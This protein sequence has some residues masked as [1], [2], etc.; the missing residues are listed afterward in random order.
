LKAAY[1][2]AGVEA[3]CVAFIDDTWPNAMRGLT[4]RSRA[5]VR[6]RCPELAA[7]GLGAL[8]AL[9]G[10]IADGKQTA[11]ADLLVNAKAAFRIA[12]DDPHGR[13]ARGTPRSHR[14]GDGARH[15]D[16]GA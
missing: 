10:V 7:I 11:N 4:S 2:D 13:R 12:Q 9:P 3:E 6:S 8:I 15:G 14:P 1:R 5:A 16:C